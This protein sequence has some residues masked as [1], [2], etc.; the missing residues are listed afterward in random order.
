MLGIDLGSATAKIVLL[1]KNFNIEYNK[2]EKIE[3]G[4]RMYLTKAIIKNTINYYK[5]ISEKILINFNRYTPEVKLNDSIKKDNILPL[6]LQFGEGWLLANEIKDMAKD[7]IKNIISL[8]PFGC[9]SNHIIAKGIYRELKS[10]LDVNL[11][12]LDYESGT[13][14]I[15]IINRLKLFL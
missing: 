10:K 7:G 12:L 1:D 6:S 3:N 2:K 5:N 11:L 15:N 14:E 13:S 4:N 9:I 8:Q